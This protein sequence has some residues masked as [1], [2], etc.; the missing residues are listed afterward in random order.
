MGTLTNFV[1]SSIISRKVN[2]ILAYV[3]G[4]SL[5]LFVSYILNMIYV[6][7]RKLSIVDFIKFVISYIPNFLILFT[8]V[9]VFISKLNVNKYLVYLMAAVIGLPVTFIILKLRTF[10]EKK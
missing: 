4:Y 2:P 3:I 8:F 6:F 5:S 1:C 10:K 7:R 9:W